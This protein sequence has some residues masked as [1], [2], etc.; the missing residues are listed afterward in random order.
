MTL[1]V[2]GDQAM[3]LL[4]QTPEK[5]G[6]KVSLG[7]RSDPNKWTQEDFISTYVVNPSENPDCAE[8]NP[9]DYISLP[10]SN[11]FLDLNGDCVPEIVLT[12]QTVEPKLISSTQ[13]AKTYY[14]IYSQ[15]FVNGASKYCLA[16]QEGQLVAPGDVRTGTSGSSKMPFIQF[17]DYNRDGVTDMAFAS[18][19]GV[20]TVL[21]NQYSVPGPKST[22]LCSDTGNTNDLKNRAM[23]ATFPFYGEQE[24]V[25]QIKLSDQTT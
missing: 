14:E 16:S 20:L 19:T 12:R 2:N 25:T 3:D 15:I 13:N 8:P 18:E 7:S 9:N 17:A 22:N 5:G 21:Y 24:G 6:I 11:A 4:Y 23:F 1:D 10:N